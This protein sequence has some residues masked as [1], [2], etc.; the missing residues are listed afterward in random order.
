MLFRAVLPGN[1]KAFAHISN[2][3]L[4]AYQ[5]LFLLVFPR[6]VLDI[7]RRLLLDSDFLGCIVDS[8]IAQKNDFLA[9]YR[10]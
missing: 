1:S 5:D 9:A 6:P 3:A 10:Q 7:Q 4:W 2:F 8:S